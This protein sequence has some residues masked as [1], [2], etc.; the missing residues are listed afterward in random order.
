MFA[1]SCECAVCFCVCVFVCLC[2]CVL[3]CLCVCVFVCLCVCVFECLCVR[4]RVRA[5]VRIMKVSFHR[6]AAVILKRL[7]E[8]FEN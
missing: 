6:C 7:E 3:V 4:A 2:V 1:T 8:Y 5:C